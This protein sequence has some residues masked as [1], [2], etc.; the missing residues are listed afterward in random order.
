MNPGTPAGAATFHV[1]LS[2]HG[3]WE[4]REE[5]GWRSLGAFVEEDD[6]CAYADGLARTCD[7]ARILV[8]GRA[9]VR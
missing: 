4:I 5:D 9:A 6:A 1:N 7:G 8:R 2:R 3:L